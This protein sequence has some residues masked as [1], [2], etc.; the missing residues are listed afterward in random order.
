MK[1]YRYPYVRFSLSL[2]AVSLYLVVLFSCAEEK[3]PYLSSI[4]EQEI[5]FS[6]NENVVEDEFTLESLGFRVAPPEGWEHVPEQVEQELFTRLEEQGIDALGG[7]DPREIFLNKQTGSTLII[8][9]NEKSLKEKI[10]SYAPKEEEI[11][12]FNHN[13]ITFYQIRKITENNINFILLFEP[14][15]KNPVG[16]VYYVNKQFYRNESKKLESS[17]GSISLIK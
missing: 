11:V 7:I 6:V 10:Q 3:D 13:G 9:T 15:E 4:K 5:Q 17:I 14:V 16:I 1:K 12:R 2:L 8:Y